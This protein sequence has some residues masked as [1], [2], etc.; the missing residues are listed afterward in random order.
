MIVTVG[1]VT[2]NASKY[3]VEALE[4]AF[5]QSYGA[6]NLVISDDCSKDNTVALVEQWIKQDRVQK[7]F[8][9]IQ[10]ITV[11]QNTGVSANCNRVIQASPTDWIKFHAGDDLLLP[12]CI[13][14]NMNYVSQNPEAQILFSQVKVYQETFEDRNY[15]NTTPH[16]FPNNLFHAGLDTQKQFEILVLCDRI[17]YTPSY[18]FHKH[19]LEKV[20]FY[21]ENERLVEDY[22]M[23]LKLTKA[24][25]RLHY[26]HTPTVGYRIHSNASNNTGSEVLFKPSVINNFNVRQKYAHPHLPWVI[27]KQETWSYYAT[28]VFK[29]LKI[30]KANALTKFLYQMITIYVNPF[31]WMNAIK[32]RISHAQ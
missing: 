24:G 6:L 11:P 9:S 18:M 20:G 29:S 8:L 17:H 21:D 7:R 27:V 3:I 14:D 16:Q 23:W 4:S 19:A 28:L 30:I 13:E 31:F 25:I 26:F 2:Y 22:P 1:V 12:K 15:I 10:L 32:K 5:E